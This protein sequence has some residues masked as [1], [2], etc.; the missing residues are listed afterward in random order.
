M[1]DTPDVL[2]DIACDY[3]AACALGEPVFAE[4]VADSHGAF[5]VSRGMATL[6]LFLAADAA[7]QT[8]TTAA[9]IVERMRET[10]GPA[11]TGAP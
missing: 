6:L 2:V 10:Y 7:D 4:T 1:K 9:Q 8:D 5:R 11:R 3:L